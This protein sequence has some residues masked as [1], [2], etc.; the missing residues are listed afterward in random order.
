MTNPTVWIS[1][2]TDELIF[3]AGKPAEPWHYVG[4]IDTTQESEFFQHIQVQL[5]RRSTAPRAAEFYLSGDPD[6]AW[7]QDAQRDPRGREPFW[8]A[9]EPFGDSRIQYSDGTAKKYFVG[10]QQAA[11]TAAM[12]RRPPEPHPG[13]RVKPVM[14]G[15]RLKRSAAGLFTTVNQPRDGNADAA[16]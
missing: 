6:S 10:I 2:S 14:I 12:S 16:G 11:V 8:I 5:G 1:T 4:T 7:V 3:D 13:R 9:I 15:I